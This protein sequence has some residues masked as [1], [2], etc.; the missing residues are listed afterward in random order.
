MD[1]PKTRTTAGAAERKYDPPR[2]MI[3]AATPDRRNTI[4]APT[5]G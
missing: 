2:D 3:F 4:F 5:P 1:R